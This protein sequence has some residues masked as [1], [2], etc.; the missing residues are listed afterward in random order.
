MKFMK[1]TC[2][3]FAS[4]LLIREKFRKVLIKWKK[5]VLIK[6]YFDLYVYLGC[7][8][9]DFTQ[10]PHI[11]SYCR[12]LIPTFDPTLKT[13]KS[14]MI[15]H[16]YYEII[17]DLFIIK[18]GSYRLCVSLP[19]REKISPFRW[20]FSKLWIGHHNRAFPSSPYDPLKMQRNLVAKFGG[21]EKEWLYLNH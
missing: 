4:K 15:M 14:N 5:T 17:Y 19:G 18:K 1:F 2:F 9:F 21:K 7:S 10:D 12:S 16:D 11:V 8:F 6:P 13:K 20:T 3:D